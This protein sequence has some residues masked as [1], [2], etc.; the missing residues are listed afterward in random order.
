MNSTTLPTRA[1][2]DVIEA[3]Y[4][5]WLDNPDALDPTWRA[6]FQGFSL[7][8][9]G[10]PVGG[11]LEGQGAGSPIIDS[12]RQS[13]VHY[14]IAAYRAIGHLQ[15]HLDPLSGP[16][17][18][19]PKLDRCEA[20]GSWAYR[21][22]AW[23][24]TSGA[25]PSRSARWSTSPWEAAQRTLLRAAR[26]LARPAYVQAS[27]G[28]VTWSPL[29][30]EPASASAIVRWS[31]ES[32][33]RAASASARLAWR[34][35]R[36]CADTCAASIRRLSEFS[37]SSCRF[38]WRAAASAKAWCAAS[39]RPRSTSTMAIAAAARNTTQLEAAAFIALEPCRRRRHRAPGKTIDYWN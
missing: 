10:G 14:L 7:G 35:A 25:N 33:A 37:S 11:L 16:P 22:S 27:T 20:A 15:A 4:R 29:E 18:P 12:L 24:R 9:N 38:C 21:D 6:F 3:M 28:S 30:S 19:V 5:R 2:S 13:H 36:S 31:S 26:G 1:N 32:L 23:A 17:P 39:R 8:S 34:R